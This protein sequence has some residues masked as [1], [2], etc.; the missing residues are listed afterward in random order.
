MFLLRV[1]ALNLKKLIT[2]I[3]KYYFYYAVLF[4]LFA[5]EVYS[6]IFGSWA[7]LLEQI[8]NAQLDQEFLTIY[9]DDCLCVPSDSKSTEIWRKM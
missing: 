3:I 9:K 5:Y 6:F 2:V 1:K 4:Q 8:V 7:N